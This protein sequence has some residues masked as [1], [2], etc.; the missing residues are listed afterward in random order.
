[1]AHGKTKRAV[2]SIVG[3]VVFWTIATGAT[4]TQSG[5]PVLAYQ[6]THVDTG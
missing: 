6:L 5:K 2:F 4:M 1:M 3:V